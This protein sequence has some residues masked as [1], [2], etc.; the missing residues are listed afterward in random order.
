VE[1]EI[2]AY[3]MIGKYFSNLK[4]STELWK[5]S[6]IWKEDIWMMLSKRA[7]DLLPEDIKLAFSYKWKKSTSA[8]CQD[9]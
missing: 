6:I 2:S 9:E 8:N 3:F 1:D 5:E 4:V 7:K